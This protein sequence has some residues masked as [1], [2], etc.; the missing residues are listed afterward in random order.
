MSRKGRPAAEQALYGER[1]LKLVAS[2]K[3]IRK[4]AEEVGLPRDTGH[5]YYQAALRKA[6][7][8]TEGLRQ[9]LVHQD[10]ESLRLLIEAHMPLATAHGDEK[11]AGVVLRALGQRAKLL[12][13]EEALKIEVQTSRVDDALTQIVAIMD[14]QRSDPQTVEILRAQVGDA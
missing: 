14:A 5:R 3:S 10:L 1:M 8:E 6:A 4:A 7:Q 12:G 11:S 2:G 9:D 13:L